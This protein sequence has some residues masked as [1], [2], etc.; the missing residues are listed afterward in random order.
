MSE[1]KLDKALDTLE[2]LSQ[3]EEARQRYYDR[4]KF[5]M[6]EASRIKAARTAESRGLEKGMEPGRAEGEKEGKRAAALDMLAMD[7]DEQMVAKA[8]GL[9][10]EEIR[11]L[12]GGSR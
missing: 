7:L 3:D 2:V 10:L 4:Q 8:T 6:D 5:L 11:S 9:D 12:R 1:P